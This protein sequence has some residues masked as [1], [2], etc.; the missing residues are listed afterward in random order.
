MQDVL[1][2]FLTKGPSHGYEL[3]HRLHEALGPMAA[4]LNAGQVYVTLRRLEK[5][6]M[7]A[8]E[9]IGQSDRP[10][11]KVYELTAAGQERV[12]LWLSELAWPKAAPTDFHLKLVAAA[13]AALADPVALADAQRRELLRQLSDVEQSRLAEADHT[14]AGLML[15]GL[16]LRLQ[17]DI[18]WLES[19]AR[20]WARR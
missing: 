20:H 10:D 18:R 9:Q 19:C 12:R 4:G 7:V 13:S 3:R 5:A 6:G 8:T 16:S 1:L 2:A 14:T 15:E 11:R 17:A